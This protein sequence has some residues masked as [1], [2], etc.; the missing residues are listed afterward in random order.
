MNRIYIITLSCILTAVMML[1]GCGSKNADEGCLPASPY[2]GRETVDLSGYASM[3]DYEGESR[4]A[5]TT[6]SEIDQLMKDGESFIFIAAFEDCDYCNVL[7]RLPMRALTQA[8]LI[9]E[10][11]RHG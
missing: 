4:L 3:S 2:D 9:Q 6:V 7:M 11:T 5:D 10:K 1:T 8:I